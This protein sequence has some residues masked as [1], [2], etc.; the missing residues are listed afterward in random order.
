MLSTLFA[1]GVFAANTG[2]VH[3]DTVNGTDTA[4]AVQTTT[5]TADS[6]Q[7]AANTAENTAA[8]TAENNAVNNK[9]QTVSVDKPQVQENFTG[10]INYKPGYGV[11][12]W[13]LNEDQSLTWIQPASSGFRF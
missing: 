3:A 10:Q 11:N 4:T 13:K 8:N 7:T 12:L 1:A 5:Q 9:Q 6:T 2:V